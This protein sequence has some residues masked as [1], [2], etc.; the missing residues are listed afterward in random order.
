MMRQKRSQNKY[1]K[2]MV[3]SAHTGNKL[4]A[5]PLKSACAMTCAYSPSGVLV[6]VSCGGLD[7]RVSISRLNA[8]DLKKLN[9]I[10]N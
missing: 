3:W 6:Y 10:M 4:I 5:I 9:H 7:N 1:C 2:L 8:N